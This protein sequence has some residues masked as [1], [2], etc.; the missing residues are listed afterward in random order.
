MNMPPLPAPDVDDY[1][2]VAWKEEKLRAYARAYA[3]QETAS[4]KTELM[5]AYE[6]GEQTVKDAVEILRQLRAA[7]QET[8][9]LR[10]DAERYRYLRDRHPVTSA[11]PAL[12]EAIDIAIGAKETR[13]ESDRLEDEALEQYATARESAASIRLSAARYE[14]LRDERNWSESGPTPVVATCESTLYGTA[15]D[16]AIDAARAALA[17]KP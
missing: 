9:A 12:D 14:W 3:E 13:A 5:S 8:A 4:I 6:D 2:G 7:E 15:L 11:W 1:W 16:A 17:Q 10:A